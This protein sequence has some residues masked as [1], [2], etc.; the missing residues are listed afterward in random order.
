MLEKNSI[1]WE[2]FAI[3]LV[4]LA[5]TPF[6]FPLLDDFFIQKQ[7]DEIMI[8]MYMEESGGFNPK[9]IKTKKGQMIKLILISMDVT[10]G[11]GIPQ[12]GIDTGPIKPGEKVII[13]FIPDREGNYTFECTVHCSPHHHDMKGMLLVESE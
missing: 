11:F 7:Q 9:L 13:K 1:L 2:S 4:I 8:R 3:L 10:H 6:F 12:L 5:L